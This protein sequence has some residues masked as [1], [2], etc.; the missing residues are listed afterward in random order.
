VDLAYPA[1]RGEITAVAHV[2]L[3]ARDVV[4]QPLAVLDGNVAVLMAMP[5]L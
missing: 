4:G 5:D 1:V 3:R 2:C